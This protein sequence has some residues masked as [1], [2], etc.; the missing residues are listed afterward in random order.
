M[1]RLT[2]IKIIVLIVACLGIGLLFNRVR[3]L[4]EE[5]IRLENNQAIL[6][7]ENNILMAESRKYKTADSLNAIKVSEL[8]L[9]LEEYK[10]Y[11]AEDMMLINKLKL[12][13]RDMQ[14]VIDLQ[15]ETVNQLKAE[16][17]DTVI[18][19][20]E[21]A[22]ELKAF[23]YRSEWTDVNGLI[24][25]NANSVDLS[26]KNRESLVLVET[27]EYK[28]FLG[29]LWK[30]KSIKNRSVDIVSLNPNTEII[31]ANYESIEK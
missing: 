24:D 18:I 12:D 11:R 10:K 27:L 2:I 26:I 25:L 23:E 13:K 9:T 6:L 15:A 21:Q 8:R 22:Q 3:A 14:K 1:N 29:F 31:D 16:L 19:I 5:N 30:T 7:S 17:R 20:E 28:R 4:T